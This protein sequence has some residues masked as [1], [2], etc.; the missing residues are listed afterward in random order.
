MR[1]KGVG[2]FGRKFEAAYGRDNAV[3]ASV[4]IYLAGFLLVHAAME[5]Y[6]PIAP[7]PKGYNFAVVAVFFAAALIGAAVVAYAVIQLVFDP[8][9]GVSPRAAV[10]FCHALAAAIAYLAWGLVDRC[11][12]SDAPRTG[13]DGKD[14][15]GGA[16]VCN[17]SVHSAL[18]P[19]AALACD[20]LFF[21]VALAG[22]VAAAA[23]FPPSLVPTVDPSVEPGTEFPPGFDPVGRD[24]VGAILAYAKVALLARAVLE[25]CK[26]VFDY[27]ATLVA[28]VEDPELRGDL[29]ACQTKGARKFGTCPDS[30]ADAAGPG[31]AAGP[32]GGIAAPR[33][34]LVSLV[35]F[36]LGVRRALLETAGFIAAFAAVAFVYNLVP[37]AA[38]AAQTS[39]T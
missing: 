21:G 19:L 22:A 14:L 33:T 25:V 28:S 11:V 20:L 12:R 35:V 24:V 34:G 38:S 4:A 2:L 32:G 31:A 3:W 1:S 16:A 37:D 10:V 30:G 8:G 5:R 18:I 17:T 15:C 39:S 7:R 36:R 26:L 9:S 27:E 13:E 29:V 6:N 23:A